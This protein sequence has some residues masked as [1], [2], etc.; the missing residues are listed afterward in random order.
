MSYGWL[1][2]LSVVQVQQARAEQMQSWETW[3]FAT[4]S[5]FNEEG[6]IQKEGSRGGGGGSGGINF[7]DINENH[8]QI[9]KRATLFM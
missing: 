5:A 8:C 3:Y 9:I 4:A 1:L 6:Q 7:H 2:S